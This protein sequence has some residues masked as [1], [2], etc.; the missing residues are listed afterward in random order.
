MRLILE[1]VIV[2]VLIYIGWQKPFGEWIHGKAPPPPPSASV[3]SKRAAPAGTR[4]LCPA[5]KGEG[6][7]V[8]DS[9]GSG[10]TV[11]HRT[12]PCPVCLGKGFRSVVI[13]KGTKLCPDCHG[14]GIVYYAE[15]SGHPIRSA[16]CAR[17]GSTGL[18]ADVR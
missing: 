3:V 17:C 5:C 4:I 8:Y 14:M 11:D 2:G 10:K 6:V 18:V 13:A 16:N 9:T 12:Q 15:E 7:L 1:I